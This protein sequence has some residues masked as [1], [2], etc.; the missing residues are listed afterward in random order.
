MPSGD[1]ILKR[2]RTLAESIRPNSSAGIQA[3]PS[4]EARA[5]QERAPVKFLAVMRNPALK[6]P[7][8]LASCV[9][10][11]LMRLFPLPTSRFPLPTSRFPLPT[12]RFPLPA[13]RFPLPASRFPLPASRFPLP[14]SRFPLPASRFPLPASRF[15]LPASRFPLPAS[16]FPLPPPSLLLHF[17]FPLTLCS[18][19]LRVVEEGEG[20]EG[21]EPFL[22]PRL[23]ETSSSTGAASIYEHGCICGPR[24]LKPQQR[25]CLLFAAMREQELS[26]NALPAMFST[27][28]FYPGAALPSQP[29]LSSVCQTL[30]LSA[31]LA[32]PYSSLLKLGSAA[33]PSHQV[34]L[35]EHV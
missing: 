1:S 30:A 35:P 28:A 23:F 19:S 8:P 4:V 24:S 20:K 25:R 6:Y 18:F 33:H 31:I 10:L 3:P 14:A 5:Q 9:R 7:A 15:P 11:L 34:T 27:H 2:E 32:T 13:S 12:S 22:G 26:S 29:T 21:K 16:R 17:F